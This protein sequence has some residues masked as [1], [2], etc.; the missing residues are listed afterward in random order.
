MDAK[1]EQVKQDFSAARRVVYLN[2]GTVAMMPDPVFERLTGL[3]RWYNEYGPALPEARERRGDELARAREVLAAFLGA[4]ANEVVFTPDTTAGI[5]AIVSSLPLQDGDEII[6]SDIEHPAGRVP[7]AYAAERK[8]LVVRTIP[9]RDGVVE[10]EDIQRVVTDRSRVISISHVSFTTGG[11]SDLASIGQ[12][13][14]DEDMYLLVDGAQ[15]AGALDLDMRSL[16]CD[17]FAFPGYKWCLG[18]E[19]SA[20]LYISSRI[21]DLLAPPAISLGAARERDMDGGYQLKTGADLFGP[22]TQGLMEVLGLG[23]ALSYLDELGM[24]WVQDRIELLTDILVR[25]LDD[26]D[27]VTL[28]TPREFHRRAGLVAFRIRGMD[29]MEQMRELTGQFYD[30][31]VHLRVVPR[32]EAFRA[33]L[34]IFNDENDIDHLLELIG[35]YCR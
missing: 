17:A 6:V 16:N 8:G 14:R 29:T 26:M 31:G 33:S 28:V 35:Q 30:S 21:H 3:L 12:Y 11:R 27:E 7:W 9:A 20:G 24:G 2:T 34:H 22:S 13:A 15:S 4:E 10:L 19:G 32:P 23:Y 1:I 25:A 18:P 5:N